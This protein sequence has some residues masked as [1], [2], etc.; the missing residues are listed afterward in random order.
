[1]SAGIGFPTAAD[2]HIPASMSRSPELV[3][4]PELASGER[5]LWSGSHFFYDAFVRSRTVY[6]VTDQ[7]V[8]IVTSVWNREIKGLSLRTLAELSLS[9]GS[10]G[11]G[12]LS[13]GHVPA[14]NSMMTSG[15]PGANRRVAPAFRLVAGVRN[16]YELIR[17][18]QNS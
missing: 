4:Q 1:M 6:G 18:A 15:W 17:K 3:I 13:F 8:L 9:E 12:T 10:D 5:L 16:V 14:F 7:R 11:T 2:L